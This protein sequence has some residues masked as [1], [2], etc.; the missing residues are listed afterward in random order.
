MLFALV[1]WFNDYGHFWTWFGGMFG[2]A[3]VGLFLEFRD[4]PPAYVAFWQEGAEGERKTAKELFP[5]LDRGWHVVHDVEGNYGNFDHVV[6]GPG[7]LFLL[8]TKNW[9]GEVEVVDGR[10]QLRRHHDPESVRA[11]EAEHR[12][13]LYAARRLKDDVERRCGERT[14]VQSVI[15]LWSDFPSE[16]I[17]DRRCCYV[18]GKAVRPWLE[19]RATK[20][21][22]QRIERIATALR[23]M[24]AEGTRGDD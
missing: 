14:W 23:E 12:R 7:G 17:E 22:S 10:P 21:T 6:V 4:S 2:G 5:L 3:G 13:V 11:F 9:R 19:A 1:A 16:A 18:A 8:E 15:V 20:L 24:A